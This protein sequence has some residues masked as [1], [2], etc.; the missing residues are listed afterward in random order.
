MLRKRLR[1]SSLRPGLTSG[2]WNIVRSSKMGGG[3]ATVSASARTFDFVATSCEGS[4]E[5]KV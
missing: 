4:P 5:Q 1:K 3:F 2:S